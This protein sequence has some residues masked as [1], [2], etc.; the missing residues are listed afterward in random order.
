MRYAAFKTVEIVARCSPLP[1]A[2][3]LARWVSS[4]YY[5]FDRKSREGVTANLLQVHRHL[6]REPSEEDLAREA[7]RT[8]YSFAHHIVDFFRYFHMSRRQMER[9]VEF[10]GF[11]IFEE[12]LKRGRGVIAITGHI[13]SWELAG[14]IMAARGLPVSA[15][16]LAQPS[17]KLDELFQRHRLARGVQ[18]IPFGKAA[19]EC[20]RR[21]RQNGVVGLLADRDFTTHMATVSF[22]GRPAR[23]SS[24]PARL[25]RVSKAPIVPLF[26]LQ[27]PGGRFRFKTLP[28]IFPERG[29]TQEDLQARIAAALEEIIRRHP[30]QWFLFHDLWNVEA[31]AALAAAMRAER[32]ESPPVAAD[33]P[34]G[35][36]VD[37]G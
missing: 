34:R 12:L 19:R 9:L 14:G 3:G 2:Y 26:L 28:P 10:E 33:P 24:G 13:G 8:F 1:V 6:G 15:V 16:A 21:L 22:F 18:V 23:L 11:E 4:L 17:R 5:R 37:L 29:M 27:L 32:R 30:T 36:V 20:L 35:G 25:A 7:R 31:D